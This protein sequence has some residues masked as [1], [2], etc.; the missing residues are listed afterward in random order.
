MRPRTGGLLTFFRRLTPRSSAE[1][2]DDTQLLA[3]Y[4]R[5]D[6]D[7]FTTLTARHAPLVWGVC[8]RLLGDYHEAEDAFQAVFV[9][10]AHKAATL[11]G[12]PLGPWLYKVARDAALKARLRIARRRVSHALPLPEAAVWDVPQL[13][14]RERDT[15]LEEEL[16]RLPDRLRRPL[17]LCY[18]EGLTNEEAARR[19]GWPR[20]TILSRLS[21]GRERL[22]RRLL[23]RGIDWSPTVFP[24][25]LIPPTVI[26][27]AGR[28]GRLVLAGESARL[29]ISTKVLVR[30]VLAAMFVRKLKRLGLVLSLLILVATGVAGWI[31]TLPGHSATPQTPKA[32]RPAQPTPRRLIYRVTTDL[33]RELIPRPVSLFALIDA[34]AA[35]R[36]AK[37]Y[38]EGLDLEG[39][40]KD[41][42]QHRKAGDRVQFNLFFKRT[43]MDHSRA[44]NHLRYTMIG[45]GHGV[46]FAGVSSM[47]IHS[48]SD[49]TWGDF[50]LKFRDKG[51]R[52]R[53][54]SEP[55]TGNK[56]VKVSPVRTELSRYLT[57]GADC[58][59]LVLPS[60]EKAGGTIPKEVRQATSDLVKKLKLARK[61]LISFQVFPVDQPIQQPLIEEFFRFAETLGFASSSVTFR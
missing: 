31:S 48:N 30:G 46:G 25:V 15:A 14:Q 45:F 3:R 33:Q 9:V 17:I 5:G 4:L 37:A 27:A 18:L 7:A 24:M 51:R 53:E 16:G 43:R 47:Q 58:A 10:L 21:R 26:E 6:G 8:W 42:V 61:E 20:G 39:L 40:R 11:T 38:P 35:V 44:Q 54:L 34:T 36:D 2:E 23:H 59:V 12:G 28:A 52:D 60:L 49:I 50:I 32:E 57:S 19:L 55:L 29:A 56:L 41:L 1:A 13:E 22:R